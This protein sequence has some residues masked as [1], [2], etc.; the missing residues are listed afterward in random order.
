MNVNNEENHDLVD[1]NISCHNDNYK[2]LEGESEDYT[3][4]EKLN[5]DLKQLT[6]DNKKLRQELAKVNRMKKT[7]NSRITQLR[8]NNEILKNEL[9]M[10]NKLIA[11]LYKFKAYYEE[12]NENQISDDLILGY[13]SKEVLNKL[14]NE[15]VKIISEKNENQ[16]LININKKSKGKLKLPK[17]TD[18]Q[19]KLTLNNRSHYDTNNSNVENNENQDDIQTNGSNKRV[20]PP[21]KCHYDGCDYTTNRTL[22]LNEHVNASHTGQRPY[23]CHIQDCDKV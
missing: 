14:Q 15:Y 22:R 18:K 8:N 13:E 20:K 11:I 1:N 9:S 19:L 21:F 17:I 12:K 3:P 6:N 16:I 4:I 23:K 7:K 5:N 10:A 2:N